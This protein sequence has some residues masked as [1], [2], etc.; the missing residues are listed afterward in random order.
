MSAVKEIVNDLFLGFEDC[1]RLKELGGEGGAMRARKGE[2][3]ASFFNGIIG[4]VIEK[5]KLNYNVQQNVRASN[6]KTGVTVTMDNCVLLGKIP[7]FHIESKDYTDAKMYKTFLGDN[8]Q[9][10][11]LHPKM[12]FISLSGWVAC[13]ADKQAAWNSVYGFLS[14]HVYADSLLNVSRKAD[15]NL[16]ILDYTKAQIMTASEELIERLSDFIK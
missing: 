14:G 3:W 16:F 15:N 5:N 11:D 9:L 13:K 1:K 2:T 10:R 7:L 4:I 8:L 6:T 12:K